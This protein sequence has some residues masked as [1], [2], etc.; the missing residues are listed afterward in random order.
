MEGT[1]KR[2]RET[3]GS[4]AE[5][6]SGLYSSAS[7][8]TRRTFNHAVQGAITGGVAGLML[9]GGRLRAAFSGAVVG[10]V[11]G[12]GVSLYRWATSGRAGNG[13]SGTDI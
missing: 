5:D 2:I 12:A 11:V 3:F 9:T 7:T 1:G 6:V 4:L 13:P 10:F 8:L